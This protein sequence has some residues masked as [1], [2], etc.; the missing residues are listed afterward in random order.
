MRVASHPRLDGLL[1]R[2][3]AAG[4]PGGVRFLCH[5]V[6]CLEGNQLHRS[7]QKWTDVTEEAAVTGCATCNADL[8]RSFGRRLGC[9]LSQMHALSAIDRLVHR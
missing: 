4:V 3:A 8:S 1:E 2:R 6:A 7:F 9:L 5:D